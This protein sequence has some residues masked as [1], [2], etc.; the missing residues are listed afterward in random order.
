MGAWRQDVLQIDG[1]TVRSQM[2]GDGPHVLL[3]HGWGGAI[4]SFA[5][6]L[7]DLCQSYTVAAF[8]LPGF[9]KSSVP[10][11]PGARRIMRV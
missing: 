9:G 8:D 4:E 2:G 3:L 11:T 7:T 6:V 1:L 5:P 10:P